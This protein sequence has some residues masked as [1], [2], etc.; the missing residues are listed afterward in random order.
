[1]YLHVHSNMENSSWKT[2]PYPPFSTPN[3]PPTVH[4]LE[5]VPTAE[6]T[7]LTSDIL[8]AWRYIDNGV[9]DQTS[10]VR[11]KYWRHWEEY[12]RHFNRNPRRTN[13]SKLEEGIILADFAVWFKIS[14]Y[15]RKLQVTVQTVS[16]AI[17]AV[18][19]TIKQAGQQ[20][21]VYRAPNKY[22][23]PVERFLEGMWCIPAPSIP[24]LAVSVAVP[25]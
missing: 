20:R 1:M 8:R 12:C 25:K 23:L 13:K 4:L 19:K 2:C 7:D 3:F 14:H 21:P 16:N 5:G 10:K 6:K 11:Y 9:T 24:K 18:S 17:S 15:D 22:I